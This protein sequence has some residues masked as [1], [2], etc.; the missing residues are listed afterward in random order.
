MIIAFYEDITN[1]SWLSIF[2][3]ISS[4]L[5]GLGVFALT[6]YA[7]WLYH[8]SRKITITSFSPRKDIF[9][10]NNLNCTIYNKTMSP[11]TITSISVV[12]NNSQMMIVKT[13]NEPFLLEP[14]HAYN[15]IGDRYS[16][17]ID[18]PL[19]ED[20]YFKL[21][22]PEKTINVKFSGK[23]IKNKKLDV[24]TKVS[25]PFDGEV[26]SEGVHYVLVYWTK[27]EKE[28]KKVLILDSGMMDKDIFN[29]N[30]VP[31]EILGKEK[32]MIH[33]FKDSFKNPEMN[34][35]IHNLRRKKDNQ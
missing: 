5:G 23:I 18:I 30:V 35:I 1:Q 10:G 19:F 14:F 4:I 20:I 34:F 9:Y 32:E 12:F 7:F 11:K 26:I 28:Y 13:F 21:G 3:S 15:I 29:F 25:I 8:F 22:T 16:N 27:G 17:N 2:E 33:F 6:A 24:L 31:K